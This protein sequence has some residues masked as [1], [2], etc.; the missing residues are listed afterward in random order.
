MSCIT[1]CIFKY[2][3]QQTNIKSIFIFEGL[4]WLKQFIKD[5]I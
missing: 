1:I 2:I 3:E 4:N 5:E